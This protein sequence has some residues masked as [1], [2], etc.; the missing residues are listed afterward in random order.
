MRTSLGYPFMIDV[1]NPGVAKMFANRTEQE[2]GQ[3]L[4]RALLR[5]R[6]AGILALTVALGG[7]DGLLEVSLPGNVT[8]ADLG[9]TVSATLVLSVQGS[10]ENAW[11]DYERFA[12]HQSDE[13]NQQSGNRQ[14]KQAGLRLLDPGFQYYIGGV[15][16]PL[17][18]TFQ[19]SIE[20]SDRIAA[21]SAEEVP[22]KAEHIAKIKGYGAWPLIALAEGMCGSPIGGSEEVHG[23]SA[24]FSL[25]ETAFSEALTLASAAGLTNFEALARQG[26]ARAR[27]G[28]G[29]FPGAIADAEAVPED[30]EFLVTRDSNPGARRNQIYNNLNGD[31]QVQKIGSVPGNY[32]DLEWKGVPDFRIQVEH[33]GVLSYD[34]AT[35]HHRLANKHTD[36]SSPSVLAS[37]EMAQ[38]VI[39]D[40]AAQSGDLT[41][42]RQVLNGFHQRANIPP[43][44]EPD[45]STQD[46][47]VR[48]VIQERSR[49]FFAEG[50]YRLYDHN[51]WRGTQFEIPFLGEPG[52]FYPDGLDHH[53]ERFG[54]TTCLPVPRNETTPSGGVTERIP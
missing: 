39:A 20:F 2:R 11:S 23:A 41:R 29:D 51:R 3:W 8:E 45:I 18:V 27:L 5:I 13:W 35:E 7:C 49:Q 28:L 33:T 48:H 19:E 15:W 1:Q 25:A 21:F 42:A 16:V 54:T 4:R 34:F 22:N 9:P 53:G 43:I 44:T 47:V 14:R 52:S 32:W 50:G 38:M 46:E 26:R 17:H 30:F 37:W 24:L 6:I 36:A 40:A 10:L 12:S 31:D